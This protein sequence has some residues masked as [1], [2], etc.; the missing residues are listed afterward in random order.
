[1]GT[2]SFLVNA[3][4]EFAPK[5]NTDI[6]N[7]LTVPQ[8][9][10]FEKSIDEMWKTVA[11]DF[12]P[13]LKYRGYHVCQP[14]EEFINEP[15]QKRGSRPEVDVAPNDIY[16]TK[17]L[18]D[19]IDKDGVVEKIS[20][21]MFLPFVREAG[22]LMLSGARY[23]I[24]PMLGDVVLS[25]ENGKVFCQFSRAKFHIHNVMH[26]LMIDDTVSSFNIP[27]ARLYNLSTSKETI[28]ISLLHYM[29]AKYGLRGTFKKF[30]P[31]VP[32]LF[33]D[34]APDP[35]QYPADQWVTIKSHKPTIKPFYGGTNVVVLAK[36]SEWEAAPFWS[37]TMMASL[38]YILDRFGSGGA[39]IWGGEMRAAEKWSEDTTHW[40]LLM[41]LILW[42]RTKN[43]AIIV[44]DIHK[45]IS[46]LDRYIDDMVRPRAQRIGFTGRDLYDFFAMCVECWEDWA[47]N[48]YKKSAPVYDKELNVLY[49]VNNKIMQAIFKFYFDLENE[50]AK[51]PITADTVRKL[52]KDKIKTRM[53]F[54]IRK[55]SNSYVTPI[56]YSGDNKFCKI[57]ATVVPQKGNSAGGDGAGAASVR[58]HASIGEVTSALN[59]TKK[60]STGLTR[61][62]PYV[63]LDNL[64]YVRR[65]PNVSWLTDKVQAILDQ[66]MKTDL[67]STLSDDL[68]IDELRRGA[69]DDD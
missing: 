7:G 42:E 44:E 16:M 53:I 41:G 10:F 11:K 15:R 27:W 59:L 60:E 64:M 29:L 35:E 61:F 52:L 18:F 32:V 2:D 39:A 5:V 6:M 45:H 23:V 22:T 20:F 56:A 21:Y 65:N 36:R 9:Q 12:P 17:Y 37:K 49:Q 13:P 63:Q 55:D 1:M 67:P 25:Y 34:E 62:N 68:D 57:T 38:Y 46:S 47:L 28:R 40:R 33:F 3:M 30:M 50:V 19:F 58:L 8:M 26:T 69:G 14:D 66:D 4:R 48:W 24:S 31:K 51:A 43:P 54:H